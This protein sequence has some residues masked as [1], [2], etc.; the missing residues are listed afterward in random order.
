MQNTLYTAV[1]N[2]HTGLSKEKYCEIT[3][4]LIEVI[5]KNGLTIR[6]AQKILIDCADLIL[7]IK[8]T[9]DSTYNERNIYESSEFDTD[10]IYELKQIRE[11]LDYLPIRLSI[12]KS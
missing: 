11:S 8:I 2:Q 9:P 10:P 4:D 3:H 7:N 6:Q 1:S 5:K 12:N